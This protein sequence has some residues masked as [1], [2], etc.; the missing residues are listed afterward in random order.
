M[1]IKELIKDFEKK[2][3]G[4]F[5]SASIQVCEWNK[6]A[7]RTNAKKHCYKQDFYGADTLSCHQIAPTTFWCNNSCVFCWRPKEYMGSKPSV[8]AKPKEMI[9][10]LIEKRKKLLQGFYGSQK[11]SVVD[12]ALKQKHWALSL[13]GEPTLYKQLPELIRELKERKGTET[14]FLVT[15]GQNP[16]MLLQLKDKK[17]LPTQLYVSMQGPNEVLYKKITCNQERAGWKKYLQTLAMLPLLGTR[18]VIR[19]TV[20]KGMNDSK[21]TIREFAEMLSA[22]KPDFVEIKSY[23]WIGFSRK[24]LVKENMPTH[25]E[26]KQFTKKLL[27]NLKNYGLENEKKDSRIVLLKNK[28]SKYK[29]KIINR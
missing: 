11:A 20:I 28:K 5:D 26:I 18:T 24:R 1:E 7:L 19:I 6:Q 21:E 22:T 9:E 8:K 3:Y 13:S 14:V 16:K 25:K 17:S 10:N 15:N 29:T 23:M 4:F 27:K 2:Q 12:K